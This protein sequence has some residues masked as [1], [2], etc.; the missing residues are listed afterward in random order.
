MGT[1]ALPECFRSPAPIWPASDSK[2]SWIYPLCFFSF[3]SAPLQVLDILPKTTRFRYSSPFPP[4]CQKFWESVFSLPPLFWF[5]VFFHRASFGNKLQLGLDPFNFP[6]MP[7]LLFYC[8]FLE[9]G[10]A[11]SLRAFPL[12]SSPLFSLPPDN[13]SPRELGAVTFLPTF[14]PF[15]F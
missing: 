8:S 4:H 5:G 7:V 9:D 6:P 2:Q 11:A 15:F 3:T 13:H 14:Y 10:S 1:G 12:F